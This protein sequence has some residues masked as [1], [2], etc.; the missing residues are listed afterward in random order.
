MKFKFDKHSSKVIDYFIFPRIYY[1]SEDQERALDQSVQ[2]VIPDEYKGFAEKM[3]IKLEPYAEEIKQFYDDDIYGEYDFLSILNHAYPVYSYHD[4]HEYIDYL[5]KVESKSFK[6]EILKSLVNLEEDEP[7]DVEVLNDSQAM[8][9]INSLKITSANK[10]NLLLMIQNPKDYL[11]KWVNLLHKTQTIFYQV[12]Q[13][14]EEKVVKVGEDI[15][16]RLS[17]NPNESFKKITYDAVQFDFSNQDSC[18][19]YVSAI[20]PYTLRFVGDSECRIVWGMEMEYSFRRIHEINEDHLMQR[21][22]IFKT[23]GD[24]TRYETL[25][26]IAKGET[27]I[28]N[29]ADELDVSSATISYHINEFLTSGLLHLSKEKNKKTRYVVDYKKLNEIIESLKADLLIDD[30]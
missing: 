16:K 29:I 2:K 7:N 26:L 20:F 27:S 11:E 17:K 19:L 23:L 13:Q 9:Y 30:K 6:D 28:K 25:K 4:E 14:Y 18:F 5:F 10:W 21:V 3:K 8:Q 22:K 24:R 15:S 1:F 12:Y